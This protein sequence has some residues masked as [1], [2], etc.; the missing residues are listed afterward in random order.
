MHNPNFYIQTG[1]P[2]YEAEK[3]MIMVHG[4]GASVHGILSLKD[5]LEVSDFGLIAPQATN[6]SWYPH[7]FMMPTAMNE[8]D[9]S[10]ALAVL[11]SLVQKLQ[12]EHQLKTEQIYLLGF[13]QGACLTLEFVAQNAARYGG[14]F[15]LSGGL[16]GPDGIV[17]NYKGKLDQTPIFLGCSTN[18]SHI[19]RHRVEE[20]ERVLTAM[21]A[22]VRMKLYP[23]MAHTVIDD[24]IEIVNRVLTTGGFI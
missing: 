5:Q 21:G 16:I 14:V 24:E 3:V 12:I 15:C 7:S 2:L 10:S 17:R 6:N 20:S 8:P 9:L 23:N 1:K 4:R 13:S 11:K 22:N 19:P 18:D